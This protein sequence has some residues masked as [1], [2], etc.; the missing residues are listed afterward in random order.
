MVKGGVATDT[1]AHVKFSELYSTVKSRS[2]D[3]MRKEM[4]VATSFVCLLH[5]ANEKVLLAY[6]AW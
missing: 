5:L 6:G 2:S 3:N 4:S 1:D